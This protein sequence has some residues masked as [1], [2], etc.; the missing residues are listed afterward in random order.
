MAIEL[1]CQKDRRPKGGSSVA[2]EA[3]VLASGNR[4]PKIEAKGWLNGPPVPLAKGGARVLVVDFWAH[5]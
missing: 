4:M 2:P 3:V 5:W 1:F